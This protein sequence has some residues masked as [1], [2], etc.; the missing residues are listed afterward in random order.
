[1]CGNPSL[2]WWAE[3]KPVV[4]AEKA[5]CF[6]NWIFSVLVYSYQDVKNKSTNFPWSFYENLNKCTHLNRVCRSWTQRV[7]YCVVYG[8]T[9][10]IQWIRS[11]NC[12]TS[13]QKLDLQ[14]IKW[15]LGFVGTES[16]SQCVCQFG[17]HITQI[18]FVKEDWGILEH[19]NRRII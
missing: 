13:K 17:C 2:V 10:I 14:M 3:P 5:E 7:V 4:S 12:V 1:M 19:G 11:Q 9:R 6:K 18:W 16:F 8:W 15:D